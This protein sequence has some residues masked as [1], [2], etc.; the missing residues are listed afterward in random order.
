MN[1]R[2]FIY[3]INQADT[4]LGNSGGYRHYKYNLEQ[5][6][7]PVPTP[8][9]EAAVTALVEKILAEKT[10]DLLQAD[11]SVLEAELDRLV[12]AL[13]GLTDEDIAVVE[14]EAEVE[15]TVRV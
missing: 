8:E 15:Y 4:P 13:Y 12:Y 2:L 14:Y 7:I 6:P 9:Q 11:T 5:I 1:S 10:K 3:M